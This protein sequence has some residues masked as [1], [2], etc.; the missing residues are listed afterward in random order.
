MNTAYLLLGGNIGDRKLVINK[1]IELIHASCGKVIKKSS[2]YESAPWGFEA[3][4]QFINQ[5]I[6]IETAMSAEDLLLNL[7]NIELLLGRIRNNTSNYS[8]RNI[9]I[10]I[11]FFNDEVINEQTIK[12]PHPLMQE[13]KFTLLPLNEIASELH[14]PIFNKTVKE[15]LNDC[16]DHLDVVKL[17]E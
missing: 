14:H 11:L 1:T 12:I 17:E 4:N 2:L 8:S 7:L 10:D 9:D 15:L 3:K 16:K 13:R 6:L 5:V